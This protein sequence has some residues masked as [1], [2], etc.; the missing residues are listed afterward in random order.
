LT[1]SSQT[2]II[3]I[4]APRL[5]ALA[6][7]SKDAVFALMGNIMTSPKNINTIFYIDGFNLYFGLK[8]YRDKFKG[9]CYYWLNLE[10]L[11][12]KII[13]PHPEQHLTAV[14]YFTARI[15]GNQSKVNRQNV[16][17]QAI[18]TLPLV[19]IIYGQYLS[20]NKQ[21][22]FCKN[23]FTK[24]EEKMTDVNI[25]VN[26]LT[27]AY[28]NHFDVAYLISA[29]TD[30]VPVVREVRRLFPQKSVIACFPPTR[31]CD[32]L[33]QNCNSIK[34]IKKY[35]DDDCLLPEVVINKTGYSLKKPMSWC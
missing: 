1:F 2:C 28:S 22:K 14:K 29:D 30:L 20:N 24:D 10:S 21:C 15:S 9:K 23:F 31:K 6:S 12:K 19:Q 13:N 35:L 18:E 3:K 11:C 4:T 8:D 16:F 26:M 32:L 17:L 5:T 25:A 33:K 27:D 34:K 7:A